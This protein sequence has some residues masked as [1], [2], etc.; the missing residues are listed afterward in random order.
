M[1]NMN[2]E[3]SRKAE[4]TATAII[5]AALRIHRSIGP[6]LLESVYETL[7]GDRLTGNGLRVERQKHVSIK[8]DGRYFSE[9]LSHRSP[10]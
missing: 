9:A 3:N 5:A 6:G 1:E 2:S 8:I 4:E 10:G 7:L